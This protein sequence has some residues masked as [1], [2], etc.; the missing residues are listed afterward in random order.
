MKLLSTE[1]GQNSVEMTFA[2]DAD[3]EAAATFLVAR[4]PKAC[5][6][7][8]SLAWNRYWALSQLQESLAVIL[9]DE[10]KLMQGQK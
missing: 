8:K 4:F 7:S 9:E 1:F 6:H 10:R 5:D 2:D 3:L